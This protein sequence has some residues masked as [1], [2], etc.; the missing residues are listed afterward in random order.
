MSDCDLCDGVMD[1]SLPQ[2][3]VVLASQNWLAWVHPGYEVPGWILTG[4]RRHAEGPTGMNGEE[5][6]EFGD[7]VAG[8]ARAI[9]DVSG[10]ERMY[11]VAF[12]DSSPHWHLLLA[13]RMPGI[14]SETGGPALLLQREQHLDT[15]EALAVATGLQEHL[16][17]SPIGLIGEGQA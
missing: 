8:L 6:A 9:E 4:L 16:A 3:R 1:G 17:A 12:G 15:D 2:E 5:R 14:P 11:V 10:A 13:A 7:L